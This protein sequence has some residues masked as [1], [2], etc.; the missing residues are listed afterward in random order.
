M[1][2][3]NIH[4]ALDLDRT[5]ATFHSGQDLNTVGEPILPMVKNVKKWLKLGYNVTIF[6]ARV[7]THFK[8][9]GKRGPAFIES[10]KRLITNFLVEN[11]LPALDITANKSPNFTH[12]VD[13]KAVRSIPNEGIMICLGDEFL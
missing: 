11:G 6:T 8:K 10:Q 12:F 4:I 9:G 7:S 1:H 5:L 2:A 13:D 3:K